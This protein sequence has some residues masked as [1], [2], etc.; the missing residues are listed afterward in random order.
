MTSLAPG[1]RSETADA[2][3][4]LGSDQVAD[5]VGV[6]DPPGARDRIARAPGAGSSGAAALFGAGLA[7][8]GTVLLARLLIGA[9]YQPS[10][11][12]LPDA[13]PVTATALPLVRLGQEISGI[14]VVGLLLVRLLLGS[15]VW[16]G[17]APLERRLGSATV[18]WAGAW[19]ATSAATWVLSLSDLAGVPVT[20]LPSRADVI[21]LLFGTD[22]MLSL[23][24][25]L[26][27]AVLM[28]CFGRRF[29]GR[30]GLSVLLVS[31][32]AGLMPLAL[33]GHVAHHN[34]NITLA[35]L[36]LA[37]HVAAAALWVGGLLV[38]VVHL[39]RDPVALAVTV[40]RFSALALVCVAVVGLS[41][42]VASVAMLDGWVE[43]FGTDRGVLTLAK[44]AALVVL[45]GVGA[46][47]RRRTVGQV[48][49]GRIGPL[50]RAGAVEL[51]LMSAAIGLAVVLS[52][53]A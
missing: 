24:A 50:L 10:P 3:T 13:G 16:S 15:D 30:V 39:R 21:P 41:G 4:G 37:G 8:L 7:G 29:D 33:T 46:W 6:A 53:T 23:S 48:A 44:V 43:L 49:Y 1:P 27:V 45:V 19:V 18:G 20:G 47:H 9:Q 32:V 11:I 22:R 51:G 25:T 40:P 17:R 12:G 31:A 5:Q 14:A 34:A 35:T 26:W 36:A 42:V 28:T 52:G 38:L 2:A